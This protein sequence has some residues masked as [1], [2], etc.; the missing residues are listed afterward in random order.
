MPYDNILPLALLR[1]V[2]LMFYDRLWLLRSSINILKANALLV[3]SCN[4]V[5][6]AIPSKLY[7]PLKQTAL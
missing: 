5:N 3:V 2:M 1:Y 7:A 6:R 4:I